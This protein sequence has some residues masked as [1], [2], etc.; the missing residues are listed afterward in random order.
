MSYWWNSY[1]DFFFNGQWFLCQFWKILYLI[2]V[3]SDFSLMFSSK[4]FIADL[5]LLFILSNMIFRVSGIGLEFL[6]ICHLHCSR[7]ICWKYCTFPIKL[8]VYLC[9]RLIIHLFISRTG[10]YSVL[11]ICDS[12]IWTNLHNLSIA[13]SWGINACNVNS[14]ITL[15]FNLFYCLN[16]LFSFIHFWICLPVSKNYSAKD[17]VEMLWNL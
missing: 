2:Q 14:P 11:L 13:L 9:L 4:P 7:T 12:I 15:F 8:S 1:N 3:H 10:F 5:G 6:Y 17:F 16:Y